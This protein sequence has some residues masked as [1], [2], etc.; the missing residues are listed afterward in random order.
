MNGSDSVANDHRA[1]VRASSGIPWWRRD[2][3]GVLVIV[4]VTA[5]VW[6]MRRRGPAWSMEEAM[7]LQ[8]PARVLDGAAPGV[9]FDWFYGPLSLL[10]PAGAYGLFAPTLI[11]ERAVGAGYLGGLGVALYFVGRRWSFPLGLAMGTIAVLIGGLALTALPIF[12]AVGCLVGAVA[13]AVSDRPVTQRAWL[14][15]L[16]CAAATGLRPE[17]ALFSIVLLGVLSLRRAV[18]GVA[19]LAFAVGL[20]PYLWLVGVAGFGPTWRNLV[21]DAVHVASERHLPWH[22]DLGGFGLLAIIGI[23]TAVLALGL[24]LRRGRDPRGV[25]LVGLGVIG[26]CL[27]PEY[28][29]RADTVHVVYFTMVPLATVVPVAY[30]L[31]GGSS[32]LRSRAGWRQAGAVVVAAVVVLGL[33]PKFV[34]RST[35]RDA[36]TFLRGGI[37]HDAA[38]DGGVWYYASAASAQAHRRLVEATAAVTEPGDRLFVGPQALDRPHYFDGSF[39][40][41]L[42]ELVPHTHFYDFHPRIAHAYPDRLAAD[43]AG[44]DVA[45]LCDIDFEEA[46]RSAE[47]GSPAA[48]QVIRDRFVP[49]ETAGRC[50][51]YERVA[52]DRNGRSPR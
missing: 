31:G 29:Q 6:F 45:I 27:F 18:R 15:G 39:Y 43:V 17:F 5:A 25:A 16:A 3:T 9:D 2:A 1:R 35:L 11:V 21:A 34:A 51:L 26:V 24:G 22:A 19:W 47:S 7:M 13:F 50:T 12:G 8:A 49:V 48:N 40:T 28:L 44:A 4:V 41:L 30:E 52:P 32:V 33:R 38:H 36:R 23:L 46:N 20:A 10:I 37:V 14:V 42:P